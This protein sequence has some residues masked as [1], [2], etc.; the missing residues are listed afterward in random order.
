MGMKWLDHAPKFKRGINWGHPWKRGSLKESEVKNFINVGEVPIQSRVMAYWPDGSIKWTSHSGIF[1]ENNFLEKELYQTGTKGNSKSSY[2]AEEKYNGIYIKNTSMT[3]FF[4]KH[5]EGIHLLD[6][7]K[8]RDQLKLE[9][10][11]LIAR[12]KGQDCLSRVTQ[13]ELE[14]NGPIKCVIKVSGSIFFEEKEIQNFILRFRFYRDIQEIEIVHTILI[15]SDIPVEGIG[16]EYKVSLVG[17][18]WNRQIRLAGDDG[19]YNE[20]AQLLLSRKYGNNNGAYADQ[21]AGKI[22]ET[23]ASEADVF[24]QAKENAIW[25]DYYLSQR[26][27]NYYEI[28][29][30]TSSNYSRIKVGDGIHS[31]GLVYVG[32]RN[33]GVACAVKKFWEKTPAMIEVNGLTESHT[34]VK[35]WFWSPEETAIDFRHYSSRD[36]MLSAYEGMEE[37]RSTPIG[38]GNTSQLWLQLFENIPANDE[39]WNLAAENEIPA[40]IVMEPIDYYETKA[41][42]VW[43]LPKKETPIQKYFEKQME[44]LFDFYQLEVKQRGW[45]GYWNFGDVMHTYDPYRHTWRYD[46]GGF[47]WQNTELVPNIWLWQ[48]FLRT[49]SKEVYYMAEAMTRHT[50]EVDQYHLGEYKGLGS[51]H[52]VIHWGCQCKEVRM[53]MAGLH[54]YYYYLTCDERTRDILMDVKDNEFAL[55]RL[56]PLREFFKS[57]DNYLPIRVGPDWSS[58]VSNWLTEWERTNDSVYGEKIMTGIRCMAET[59]YKLLSGPCFMFDPVSKKI[60]Y[61][62]TGNVDSY[63]MVIS[64]GAP[65]VWMELADILK[66]DQWNRMIAEFGRFYSL[67]NE[68]KENESEHLLNDK[69]FS[70]PMFGSGMMAYAA[71]YYQDE[72]IAKRAW[73]CLLDTD[74]SGVPLPVADS[75]KTVTNWRTIKEMPWISTNVV[76]QWCINLILCLELIGDQVPIE[77][78]NKLEGKK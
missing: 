50:S 20:P 68:Q 19:I 39:L 15:A 24:V 30:R 18:N 44:D 74:I 26:N 76:S 8:E 65:Q 71:N 42:G 5:G 66:K 41:L 29:K 36:H 34:S 1:A 4:P 72:K 51:R 47:A 75:L 35:V 17:E 3:A 2:L 58:L 43:S 23:A 59:P 9:G 37:I 64:F 11:K 14:E 78:I 45:Y 16:L 52:N 69:K 21:I 7:V 25:N 38:I 49:G 57:E 60:K 46:L 6:W 27:A 54:R 73:D 61:Y 77:I 56:E 12:V 53:S 62:G 70:W 10:L 63:H 48:S 40:Q 28:L 55:E 22:V 32:G 33:G 67:S 31:K 13:L